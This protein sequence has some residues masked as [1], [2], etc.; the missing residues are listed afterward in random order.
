[1]KKLFAFI[2]ILI[3]ACILSGIYGILHDQLT[4]T[5]SPEYYTK[6]KFYQFGLKYGGSEAI[7]PNPRVMVSIIG[8]NATWWVGVP[9]GII[10]GLVGLIHEDWR[11]MVRYVSGGFLITMLVALIA[12]LSGLV[13]GFVVLADRPRASF[14]HWYIPENVV[15]FENFISVG[16][17]HNMSYAGGMMGMVFGGAYVVWMRVQARGARKFKILWTGKEKR[18]N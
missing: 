17:M 18:E 5:I 11:L 14:T 16:S 9:I 12:G 1:M 3:S 15:H 6:F 10:L 8:F 13:Y 2:V 7:F 4:Y